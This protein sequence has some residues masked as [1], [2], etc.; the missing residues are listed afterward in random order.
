MAINGSKD[1]PLAP[2]EQIGFEMTL[3]ENVGVS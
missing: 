1:M 2:S 3:L